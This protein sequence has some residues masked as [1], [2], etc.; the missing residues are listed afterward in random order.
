M[1]DGETCNHLG[2]L[3]M[4]EKLGLTI[5][6]LP[7]PYYIPVNSWD[8]IKVTEITCIEFHWFL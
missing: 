6:P 5:K 4:V 2:S 8:K 7:Y 1:I 3:E